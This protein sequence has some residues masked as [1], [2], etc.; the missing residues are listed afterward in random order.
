MR[1]KTIVIDTPLVIGCDDEVLGK[2]YNLEGWRA[3]PLWLG[4]TVLEF[5]T[6]NTTIVVIHKKKMAIND[7]RV[8]IRI[9][10]QTTR[11][12]LRATRHR[13]RI[14][15]QHENIIMLELSMHPRNPVDLYGI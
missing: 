11:Y 14:E 2:Q 15:M 6:L 8:V 4:D 5:M 3:W 7:C 10:R 1:T 12:L 13:D 9:L